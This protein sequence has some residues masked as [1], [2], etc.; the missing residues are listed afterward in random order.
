MAI[1][2]SPVDVQPLLV[3]MADRVERVALELRVHAGRIGE[4]QNR[5]A[6]AAERHTLIHGGQ[7]AATPT[8]IAAARPFAAGAEHDERR[9]VLRF[10]AQAIGDPRAHAGPAELLRA[11]VHQDLA[12][13]MIESVGH[14]RFDDG[15]VIHNLCQVRQQFGEFR[16]ALAILGEF[17]L[18]TQ[19]L[20]VGVDESSPIAFQQIRGRQGPIELG[21][22]RFIVEQLQ[23]AGSSRHEEV[24]HTFCLGRVMRLFWS[25]RIRGCACCWS[26]KGRISQQ[27]TQ[28]HGT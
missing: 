22:L 21:Q 17:E 8:G 20:R 25:Q 3:E 23:V 5:I 4:I 15:N 2:G 11:G 10:A 13:S 24:N 7:K 28:C 12:G 14:H 9:Q 18:R 19:Q 16:A 6:A 1:S 27:L 26:G